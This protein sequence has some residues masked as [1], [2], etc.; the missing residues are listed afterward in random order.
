LKTIASG[1]SYK[2]DLF[3]ETVEICAHASFLI[4][5]LSMGHVDV[6]SHGMFEV[7]FCL[8]LPL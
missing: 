8:V 6:R 2:I 7:Y 1:K 5:L 4:V 3:F